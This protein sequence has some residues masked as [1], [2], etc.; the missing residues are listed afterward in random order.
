M[1]LC[2]NIPIILRKPTA[3]LSISVNPDIYAVKLI[4]ANKCVYTGGN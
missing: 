3:L 2:Y 1:I 4:E